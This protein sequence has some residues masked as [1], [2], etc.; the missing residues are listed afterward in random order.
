MLTIYHLE[1]SRSTRVIWL[2][3]EL[4]LDYQVEVFRR[5][6]DF[7]PTADFSALHPLARSPLIRDADLV[8]PGAA[9]AQA[10][11]G[12]PACATAHRRLSGETHSTT[13]LSE[14]HDVLART[15]VRVSATGHE[16]RNIQNGGSGLYSITAVTVRACCSP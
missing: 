15:M 3:E 8:L 6:A 13:R 16:R 2:A 9:G 7:R 14:G 10:V 4:G 11:Q 5:T 1:K 12:Q